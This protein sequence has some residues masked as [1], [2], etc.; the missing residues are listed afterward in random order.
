M[1]QI[2]KNICDIHIVPGPCQ[3]QFLPLEHPACLSLREQQVSMAGI[4]D[5]GPG[6]AMGRRAPRF[7]LLLYTL[8]GGGK[9]TTAQGQARLDPGSLLIMPGMTPHAYHIA[10][11]RWRILWFHLKIRKTWSALEGTAWSIRREHRAAMLRPLMEGLLREAALASR[12]AGRA[13]QLYAELIGIELRREVRMLDDPRQRQLEEDLRRLSMEVDA[14]LAHKWTNEELARAMHLSVGHFHRLIR[15]Y[16]QV[17]PMQLVLR[18]RMQRAE[19]MLKTTDEAVAAIAAR[20]GYENAFA[21]S[22]AFKR[23]AALSPRDF[24]RRDR[25]QGT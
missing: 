7:H 19:I 25:Q 3:E 5:L 1:G 23:W 21:F 8:E 10:A 18:L 9:L 20:V 13:V 2:A 6:Y 11:R 24:R 22:V 14:S 12:D 16:F 17:T 4:S 15:R